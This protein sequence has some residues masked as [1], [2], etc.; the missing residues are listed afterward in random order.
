[1][2]LSK[3][4]CSSVLIRTDLWHIIDQNEKTIKLHIMWFIKMKN[5]D[6]M[7][8]EEKNCHDLPQTRLFGYHNYI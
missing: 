3:L 2:K 6:K 4:R 8:E 5:F 1:M 7:E